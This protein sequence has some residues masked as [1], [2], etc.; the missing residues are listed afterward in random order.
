MR[1]HSNAT[2]S[3]RQR[4]LFRSSDCSCRQ[5]AQTYAVSPTT[6]SK[7]KSR[8]CRLRLRRRSLQNWRARGGDYRRARPDPNGLPQ[9]NQRGRFHVAQPRRASDGA[10]RGVEAITSFIHVSH[11]GKS[12]FCTN[13]LPLSSR[14]AHAQI[15]SGGIS[16]C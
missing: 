12:G 14:S 2:T 3:P 15:L 8:L 13:E 10:Q 7:W 4:C 5:L 6:V 16:F 9:G 1:I 11:E